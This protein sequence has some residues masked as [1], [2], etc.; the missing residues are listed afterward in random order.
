[1]FKVQRFGPLGEKREKDEGARIK[2]EEQWSQASMVKSSTDQLGSTDG[3]KRGGTRRERD[4]GVGKESW[5][6]PENMKNDP[7]TH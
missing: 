6:M 2:H 7:A 5:R 3:T 1:M 4:R